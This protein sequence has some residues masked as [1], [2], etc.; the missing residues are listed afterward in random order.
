MPV[1]IVTRTPIFFGWTLAE[2][3]ALLVNFKAEML[4]NGLDYVISASLNGKTTSRAQRLP[5]REWQRYL[6]KA[7]RELDPATYGNS[8]SRFVETRVVGFLDK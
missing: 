3:E 2:L 1:A 4:A 7:L 6:G 5:L 8:R